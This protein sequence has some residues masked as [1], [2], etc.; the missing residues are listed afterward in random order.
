M[1]PGFL[2]G[3][4][5]SRSMDSRAPAPPLTGRRIGEVSKSNRLTALLLQNATSADGEMSG[6]CP[7]NLLLSLFIFLFRVSQ[8]VLSQSV[9]PGE[10][11]TAGCPRG[12]ALVPL[13]ASPCSVA[14]LV[15]SPFRK[16]GCS[17]RS[18][19]NHLDCLAKKMRAVW[20]FAW[21]T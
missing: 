21:L 5:V 8:S 12:V 18:L 20:P 13:P 15:T 10:M 4:P 6:E 17:F 11:V 14:G 7:G 9:S 16:P 19:S 1:R 2:A 3:I